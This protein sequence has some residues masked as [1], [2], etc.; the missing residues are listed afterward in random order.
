M[1]TTGRFDPLPIVTEEPAVGQLVVRNS[2]GQEVFRS[3]VDDE[4]AWDGTTSLGE[5]APPDDYSFVVITSG[6]Q[7]LPA[8]MMGTVERVISTEDGNSIGLGENVTADSYT[9]AETAS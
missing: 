1:S 6:S 8:R 9:V 5:V 7:P 4:W 3:A 2:N